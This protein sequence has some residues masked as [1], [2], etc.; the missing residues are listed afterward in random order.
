MRKCMKFKRVGCLQGNL[1]SLVFLIC[2]VQKQEKVEVLWLKG[3]VKNS[4]TKITFGRPRNLNF[5]F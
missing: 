3:D 1:S 4:P 2:K 5:I